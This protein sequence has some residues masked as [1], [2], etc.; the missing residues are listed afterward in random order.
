[1]SMYLK[2]F[3]AILLIFSVLSSVNAQ[4][5]S[6][7]EIETDIFNYQP[8]IEKEPEQIGFEAANSLERKGELITLFGTLEEIAESLPKYDII[9]KKKKRSMSNY[10]KRDKDILVK[11]YW[12]GQD[13]SVNKITTALELGRIETNTRSIRIECRDHS[14]VDGD[15]V[16]LYVNDVVIRSSI[17]LRAGY[18][19]VDIVLNDGFNRVDI[20]ALN[21]GTSGPN[22]AEFIVY[23]EAGNLLASKEWNILTGYV[24]TLVVMKN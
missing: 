23:D 17:A 11:K 15:M 18:Y 6:N 22:T 2:E 1:M 13:V 3:L 14:Y 8:E 9:Q 16:R 19:A 24:A 5:D 12:D 10:Q 7:K 20:K 21:Q 4:I